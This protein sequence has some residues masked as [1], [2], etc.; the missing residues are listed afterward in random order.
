MNVLGQTGL[1][2]VEQLQKIGIE[3]YVFLLSKGTLG[4]RPC[5]EKGER[6]IGNRFPITN[7]NV[8]SAYR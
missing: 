2:C 6:L 1:A 8:K 4:F 7:E 3:D 5:G